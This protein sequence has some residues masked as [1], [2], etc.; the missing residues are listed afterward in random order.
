M[1]VFGTVQPK[2]SIIFDDIV[3]LSSLWFSNRAKFKIYS[4]Y[5]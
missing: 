2:K 4:G 1:S 3:S 5:G